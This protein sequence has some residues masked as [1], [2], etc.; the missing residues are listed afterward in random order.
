MITMINIIV[1][2]IINKMEDWV[3]KVFTLLPSLGSFPSSSSTTSLR[4]MTWLS[5]WRLFF[6]YFY[7][8]NTKFYRLR[9]MEHGFSL[10]ASIPSW[11][12]YLFFRVQFQKKGILTHCNPKCTK[13]F[14]HEIL[15]VLSCPDWPTEGRVAM[16]KLLAFGAE[17]DDIVLIL[18][19]DR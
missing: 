8:L 16:L 7:A 18:H 15:Q 12:R 9:G 19:M 4:R 11:A 10:R 17:Q 5:S 14:T 1:I 3:V 13:I 6:V 2:I